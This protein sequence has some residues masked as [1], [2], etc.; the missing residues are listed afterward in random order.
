MP[1]LGLGL[2]LAFANPRSLDADARAYINAVKAAGGTVTAGQ[3]TAINN[4]IKAEK[5]ASRWT[6]LKRMYLPIWAVAAANAIDIVTR[7][8]GTFVGD[9]THSAGFV[10]G[11]GSTGYLNL[12]ASFSTL[13]LTE[14]SGYMFALVTQ[15]STLGFR[16]LVGR[17][18]AT[19]ASSTF[20]SSN[21]GQLFRY[22]N[23]STGAVSGSSAGTGIISASREG[24][25]RAIYRRIT[26]SRS[27]LVSTAGADA[28]TITA[29][30]NVFALGVNGNAGSG[31]T[32]S[33]PTNA[34]VGAVGIGLGMTDAQDSAFT[35][36]LRTLWEQCTSLS[37]P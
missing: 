26:A 37:L 32:L 31:E 25:N 11:D 12:N 5:A 24:G 21:S 17:S 19:T 18:S 36:N 34:R 4:F 16:G 27:T 8:S 7:A 1:A 15:A 10:Q 35:T 13:A 9:V 33:D 29:A 30:G 14:S 6:L 23:T 3:T 28:G 2:G 22:N 20:L